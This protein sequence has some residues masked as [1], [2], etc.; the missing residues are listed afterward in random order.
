MN[1]PHQAKWFGLSAALHLAVAAGIS[2]VAIRDVQRTPKAIM[3]V[4]ENLDLPEISPR[5]VV[6]TPA[7]PVVRPDSQLKL[8]PEPA[9]DQP[10]QNRQFREATVVQEP[11]PKTVRVQGRSVEAAKVSAEKPAAASRPIP[12][13]VMTS[14][15]PRSPTEKA[16]QKY[17]KEHF[18]YISDLIAKRL[19]YPPMARRMNWNGRV[20]VS[21]TIA[22]DGTVHGLKVVRSSGHSILDKS[23]LETVRSAAPFPRPLVR[24]EIEV[25]IN[26]SMSQ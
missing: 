15:D 11:S 23:A 9:V 12:K 26:F 19:V 6:Q 8:K 17:L 10:Q 21:F 24:A 20:T 25:P 5:E 7:R 14:D 1:I 18:L 22:E 3:V 2:A 13:N 4:L 16:Q